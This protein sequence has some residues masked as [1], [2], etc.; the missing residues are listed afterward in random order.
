[1]ASIT[2]LK[3]FFFFWKMTLLYVTLSTCYIDSVFT[4]F[5]LEFSMSKERR[6]RFYCRKV[7]FRIIAIKSFSLH[8]FNSKE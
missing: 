6:V 7:L 8:V 4:R 5:I 2:T 1:M 3:S